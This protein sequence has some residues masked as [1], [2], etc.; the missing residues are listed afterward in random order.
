MEA[1]AKQAA[2]LGL[3]DIVHT[4]GPSPQAEISRLQQE[5]HALL[6]LGRKRDNKGHELLAG[7]KLFS[8]LKTGRPIVGILPQDET[9]KVLSRVGVS[10]VADSESPSEISAVLRQI[11]AAWSEGTLSSL[12]PDR[13]A[14]TAYSA[15]RQTAA[16][17]RAL[18]GGPAVEPF[19]PGV[20]EIPPSLRE[21]IGGGGWGEGQVMEKPRLHANA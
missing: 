12:L 10:T 1:L 18:Q 3:S 9:R 13:I 14:C 16:L 5:A 11:L 20:V 8:Y 21:E 6:I 4:A 2:A 7:A 15:E 17:V 19:I